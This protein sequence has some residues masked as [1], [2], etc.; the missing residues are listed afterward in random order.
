MGA[1]LALALAALADV[2]YPG[3]QLRPETCGLLKTVPAPASTYQAVAFSP[4]GR[5]AAAAT[6]SGEIQV[7][8]SGTWREIKRIAALAT[9]ATDVDFTTDGK[10][11]VV[12]G[13]AQE[14][15]V[16]D[17]ESGREVTKL[18]GG[19]A[20]VVSAAC[21]PN[22]RWI[23]TSG[24]DQ[25]VRVFEAGTGREVAQVRGRVF[26]TGTLAFTP[27]SRHL[28]HLDLNGALGIVST[29]D[30]QAE[31][32]IPAGVGGYTA[33][34]VGPDSKRI[35]AGDATGRVR[36]Y[37]VPDGSQAEGEWQL[38]GAQVTALA[39][40]KTGRLLLAAAGADLYL[41]D[42]RRPNEPPVKLSH[43]TGMIMGAAFSPDER[44]IL[45]VGSDGHLKVWG[46]R[47]GGMKGIKPKG[48]FGV[49]VQDNGGG[50]GIVVTTV[51]GATAAEKAGVQVNDFILRVAGV[52]VKNTAHAIALISSHTVG[53]EIEML[54]ERGG[55]EM[56]IRV[57]LGRRPEDPP[58]DE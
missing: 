25:Q 39:I 2:S 22:G 15:V 51:I 40:A 47:P 21:S 35:Y 43:H 29:E 57:E 5:V 38:G 41:I 34:A 42:T 16:W 11:V 58:P 7:I 8:R 3:A 18:G 31:G 17:L 10:R 6:S 45:S 44:F 33:V 9:A 49:Q 54:L 32:N 55:K 26:R 56:Q 30:W 28:V 1:P 50:R 4:D 20:Q 46:N 19:G 24:Y 52:E 53:A 48:F 36:A 13:Q 37:R 12:S 14:A 27:D 23:S